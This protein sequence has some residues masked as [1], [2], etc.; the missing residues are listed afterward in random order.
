VNRRT[1]VIRKGSGLVDHAGDDTQLGSEA[2]CSLHAV[3]RDRST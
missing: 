3:V 1:D 2:E